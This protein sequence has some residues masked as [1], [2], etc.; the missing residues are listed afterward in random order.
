M[1]IRYFDAPDLKHIDKTAYRFICAV[2]DHATHAPPLRKTVNHRE[3]MFAN[4]IE[5]NVLID[6]AH[7]L[8][9]V[10]A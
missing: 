3:N 8:V 2:S 1:K 9:Q 6:K 4:T 5:G 7:Q 10:A